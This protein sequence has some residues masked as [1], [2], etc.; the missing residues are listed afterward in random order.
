MK[1]FSKRNVLLGFLSIAVCV[2]AISFASKSS[3][4]YTNS[5]KKMITNNWNVH[6][7]NIDNVRYEG[8]PVVVQN[9]IIK[10]ASTTVNYMVNLKPGDSYSFE[11]DVKNAGGI[12]AELKSYVM[13]GIT[14]EQDLYVNYEVHGISN[15]Q[16]LRAG[17]SKTLTIVVSYDENVLT[18]VPLQEQALDLS[19]ILN[20]VQ[21]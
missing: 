9:P 18:N 16:V 3:G 20:F 6:F 21:D 13:S 10:G 1:N 12:D 19:F 8:N 4:M 5:I 2:M 15:G 14:E 7:R 11:I 17:E